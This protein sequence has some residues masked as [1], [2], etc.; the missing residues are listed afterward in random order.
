MI[1]S[2]ID[3]GIVVYDSGKQQEVC[4][5]NV[6]IIGVSNTSSLLLMDNDNTIVIGDTK[7]L[8]TV[9]ISDTAMPEKS[10]N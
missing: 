1:S 10:Q 8:H 7:G 5:P 3:G 2:D 4:S 6:K 9:N